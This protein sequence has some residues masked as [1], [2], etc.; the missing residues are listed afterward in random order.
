[1]TVFSVL[2]VLVLLYL[3]LKPNYCNPYKD[4][5]TVRIV[6]HSKGKLKEHLNLYTFYLVYPRFIHS[7]MMTH[8]DFSRS[9]SSSRAIPVKKIISQVWNNPAMPIYWGINK[10]G[11]QA[12][13]QFGGLKRHL[14]RNLWQL[15]GRIV[16]CIAWVMMKLGL[17]KQT[18]NRILEPWQLMHVT[19]TTCKLANFFHLRIHSD[20]QPEICH[21]ATLM[22][23]AT[24][25]STPR[26]LHKGD[27][28]L[29]WIQ[30]EDKTL[31]HEYLSKTGYPIA[32]IDILK[33]MSAARCAR[34]SYAT[35]DGERSIEKDLGTY[36]KLVESKPV[37][38]SPCEHQA[39]IDEMQ[40]V[41]MEIEDGVG[42]TTTQW[43]EP[44]LHGNLTGYI[45][46]RNLI[47]DHYFKD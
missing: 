40:K 22:L 29:P 17:H 10:P 8:K 30:E 37:H 12:D 35:F 25:A 38:S 28:H 44:H 15:A 23:S 42:F 39:T 32:L 45:Q 9:A 7:E 6:G 21:L 34:S 20:A 2:F 16:C 3:L 11:M 4:N 46:Y 13:K 31:A 5:Y 19:L 18:A 24:R 1:M 43:K 36:S 14:L 33:R 41:Y 47:K 26:I 27:W